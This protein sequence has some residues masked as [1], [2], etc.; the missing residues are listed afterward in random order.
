MFKTKYHFVIISWLSA[1]L[2]TKRSSIWTKF[3]QAIENPI[4]A[5]DGI[6][7]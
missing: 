7:L 6:A 3:V 2:G 4:K 1:L 5:M